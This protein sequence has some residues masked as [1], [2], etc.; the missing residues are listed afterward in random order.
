MSGKNK[1]VGRAHYFL[2]LFLIG[3]FI[4]AQDKPI[5]ISGGVTASSKYF[6]DNTANFGYNIKDLDYVSN[7]YISFQYDVA[8]LNLSLRKNPSYFNSG[9]PDKNYT[10]DFSLPWLTARYGD[11]NVQF[12]QNTASY[13]RIYGAEGKLNFSNKLELNSLIGKSKV[14]TPTQGYMLGSYAQQFTGHRLSVSPINEIKLGFSYLKM[15]DDASSVDFSGTP[16]NVNAHEN[17]LLG[18][19]L[20]IYL[21]RRQVNINLE[22]ITSFY[23]EDNSNVSEF[24]PELRSDSQLLK[25]IGYRYFVQNLMNTNDS[26]KAGELIVAKLAFPLFTSRNTFEYRKTS[27]SYLSL[28][29]YQDQP[30]MEKYRFTNNTRFF[31]GD[32]VLM[33]NGYYSRSNLSKTA[34]YSLYNLNLNTSISV[35]LEPIGKLMLA[36]RQSDRYNDAPLPTG[37]NYDRRINTTNRALSFTYAK[38]FGL[39]EIPLLVSGTL[40]GSWNGNRIRPSGEYDGYSIQFNTE[41]LPPSVFFW[42]SNITYGSYTYQQNGIRRYSIQLQ[43]KEGYQVMIDRLHLYGLQGYYLSKSSDNSQKSGSF[44]YGA[45]VKWFFTQ[46]AFAELQWQGNVFKDYIYTNYNYLQQYLEFSVNFNF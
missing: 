34:V 40:T 36:W 14:A 46:F 32:L 21:L 10:V 24:N 1:T 28:A 6:L 23:T 12:T 30:D 11:L 25:W 7:S 31:S 26:T 8:K 3:N 38:D 2:F 16:F 44:Q 27:K 37:K 41:A 13:L 18:S 9:L 5:I 15:S 39:W 29:S 45:G 33:I 19:D 20:N 22:Y 43:L 4:N 17:L 35:N 42:T